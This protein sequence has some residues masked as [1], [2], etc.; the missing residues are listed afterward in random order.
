MPPIKGDDMDNG[1]NISTRD[2]KDPMKILCLVGSPHGRRGNTARLLD[3]V[4]RGAASRGAVAETVFLR[5]AEVRPCRGCDRCH[6]E[7]RCPQ[8]DDFAVIKERIMAA[9]GLIMASP[10]YINHVSAQL[11]AFIDRCCGVIHCLGFEGRYGAAVVTSGGGPEKMIADYLNQFLIMTGIHPVGAVHATMAEM[12]DGEFT[13]AVRRRAFHLGR[14]LVGAWNNGAR[15]PWVE[16][17]MAA[18]HARMA[19]LVT[20]RRRE[21]PFEYDWWQKHR[22]L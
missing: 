2:K 3:E 6:I 19:A 9:D 22:G 18:F 7:G 16:R 14:R 20:Y 4:L 12:P 1:L 13:E 17:R 21:W 11:K 5:G 8:R 10:N 15:Y